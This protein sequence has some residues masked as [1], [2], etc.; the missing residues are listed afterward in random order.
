[1]KVA[2]Q[3]RTRGRIPNAEMA[4]HDAALVEAAAHL[5]REHGYARLSI[6]MIARKAAVSSRTI[7]A[8]YG[9]KLGLFKAVVEAMVAA[10]L[11]G[12]DDLTPGNDPARVLTQ[13]ARHLLGYAL[14]PEVLAIK[15][16]LIGEATYLPD[17][18]LLYYDHGPRQGLAKLSGYLRSLNS[19][20]VVIFA[21]PEQAADA[22][23]SLVEGQMVRRA[24]YLCEKPSEEYCERLIDYVVTVFLR[25]HGL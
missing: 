19:D 9:G 18:A 15:R 10:P 7:Y 12:F 21:D 4:N 5:F 23:V 3:A 13:A 25:G 8:R 1:M 20:Q 24:M 14:D 16:V 6:D 2:N 17:L 11:T 22:F